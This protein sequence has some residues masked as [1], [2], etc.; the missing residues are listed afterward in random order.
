MLYAFI[1]MIIT[2]ISDVFRKKS[3]WYWVWWKI[4]DLLSYPTW[5]FIVLY[6]VIFW[7][8]DYEKV[9]FILIF[10]TISIILI[11]IFKTQIYQ[12]I[13]REEK[14]SLIMP[15]TNVN[16]ILTIFLSFFIFA[17][18]SLKSLIITFI[19]ILIIML[20]SIDFKTFKLPKT[21]IM[22][23]I[24]EIIWWCL[25]LFIWL[26][27]LKYWVNLY[28]SIL[29]LSWAFFLSIFSLILK[30]YKTL[31]WLN[32]SFYKNR[33]IGSL[34]WI[35]TFLSLVVIK[36]LGLSVWIILSFFWIWVT[37]LFS[38]IF[39]W[40]KPQKKDLILTIVVSALVWLWFF[41][42]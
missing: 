17:D 6:F 2:S 36:E 20:S 33:F 38:Y 5:I 30:E 41:L 14:I 12:K 9:N 40:D 21:I 39:L 23:L 10:S 28:L 8:L 42:K 13:Y 31:K 26:I 24:W 16:K 1:S 32:F 37:L 4:H 35:A 7:L 11:S 25:N 3:L 34:W 18:V 22:L 19:A 15:Y 27:I 29:I